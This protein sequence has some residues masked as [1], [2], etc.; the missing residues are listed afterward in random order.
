MDMNTTLFFL[1]FFSAASL[2]MAALSIPMI[3]RWIKPNLWYGFRTRK[4]LSDEGVWYEANAHAGQRLLVSGVVNLV[5]L[6][7]LY[8]IPFFRAD[9]VL[10]N[11]AFLV[12]CVIGLMWAVSSSLRYLQTL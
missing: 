8:A 7:G 6:V 4:T 3:Q 12:V 1:I 10:F 5:A 9:L 11:M 2:L